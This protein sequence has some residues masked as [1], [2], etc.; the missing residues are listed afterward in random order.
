[1]VRQQKVGTIVS[2]KMDKTVIVS[3]ETRLKHKIYGKTM[4]KTKR[5]IVHNPE[6]LGEIG[7]SVI[8][9]QYLPIS[10]KKRWILKEILA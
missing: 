6:N 1:M 10:A 3:V 2:N 5:Y 7:N 8:L 4:S 9:E